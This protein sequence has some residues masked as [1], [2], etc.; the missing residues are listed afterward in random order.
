MAATNFL[1]IWYIVWLSVSGLILLVVTAILVFS[2]GAAGTG[3]AR[4]GVGKV[5]GFF[6]GAAVGG[7]ASALI[8]GSFL[9]RAAL[10][11]GGI[12]LMQSSAP[13]ALA[14]DGSFAGFD[15]TRLADR[16][17]PGCPRRAALP[18]VILVQERVIVSRQAPLGGFFIAKKC[19]APDESG[20][21]FCV[22]RAGTWRRCGRRGRGRRS[23]RGRA[24]RPSIRRGRSP[25]LHRWN[26]CE[27]SRG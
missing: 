4:S 16:H 22:V 8:W 11:I 5:I 13:T 19:P 3:F 7:G 17:R 2:G 18:R 15:T 26:P 25:P 23:R 10:L 14:Q 6:G 20:R 1:Q 21:G 12:K 24:T 27:G 9:L